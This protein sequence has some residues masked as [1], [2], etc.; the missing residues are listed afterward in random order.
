MNTCRPVRSIKRVNPLQSVVDD[1]AEPSESTAVPAGER[2][3]PVLRV[4][5]NVVH[6]HGDNDPAPALCIYV[7]RQRLAREKDIVVEGV[8]DAV[9]PGLGA[10]LT[11]R[12]TRRRDR[13][14]EGT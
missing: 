7:A 14:G 4:R 9:R 2:D 10:N 12:G 11:P 6:K 3:L 13:L 5:P 8:E 1:L